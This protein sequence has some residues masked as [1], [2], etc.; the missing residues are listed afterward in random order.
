MPWIQTHSGVA[1]NPDRAEPHDVRVEDIAHA[2][3]H[4]CRFNG[5]T[6]HFYSVAQHCV[7]ATEMFWELNLGPVPLESFTESNLDVLMAVLLHDA[8]EAYTGD[9]PRPLTRYRTD[10]AKIVDEHLQRIIFEAVGARL[11]TPLEKAAIKRIDD[12]MLATEKRDLLAKQIEW[13]GFVLPEPDKE[14]IYGWDSELAKNRFLSFFEKLRNLR[15]R[16]RS[17]WRQQ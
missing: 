5:H 12:I 17:G 15:D 13:P 9:C 1:F 8:H 11:P 3:S 7:M 2:L 16:A 10:E 6:K 14:K 4:I